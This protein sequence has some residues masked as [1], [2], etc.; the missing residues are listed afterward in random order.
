MA[1]S[2]ESVNRRMLVNLRKTVLAR[3]INGFCSGSLTVTS[4]NE[5]SGIIAAAD[6]LMLSSLSVNTSMRSR[7]RRR[8][9]IRAV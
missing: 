2:F 6:K 4:N 9:C 3:S 1:T 5:S 8:K 7:Q